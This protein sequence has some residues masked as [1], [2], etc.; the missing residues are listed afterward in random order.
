MT[1][2]TPGPPPVVARQP[3]ATVIV[4]SIPWPETASSVTVQDVSEPTAF[5]AEAASAAASVSYLI[6]SAP[7]T[8]SQVLAQSLDATG[9]AGHPLEIIQP[10]SYELWARRQR[11]TV[12][13]AEYR[14]H[15]LATSTTDNGVRSATLKING[16]RWLIA[17]ERAASGDIDAG[18]VAVIDRLFPNQHWVY[19]HRVDTARQAISWY[20]ALKSEV[21]RKESR[22]ASTMATEVDPDWA[23]VR[24]LDDVA[25]SHD[26]R[27]RHFFATNAIDPLVIAYEEVRADVVSVVR[28]I[29]EV[30][31]V[32]EPAGFADYEPELQQMSDDVTDRWLESY[33]AKRDDLPPSPWAAGDV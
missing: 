23:R 13:F 16:L 31:G 18:E 9:V 32:E 22:E 28:R 12:R 7:R 2:I 14:D 3:P 20:R 15:C 11:R 1:R 29:L 25:Q 33:L 24:W 8:G 17:H 5:I 6:A 30:V 4:G 27:W 26:R 10:W 21:W 19:L